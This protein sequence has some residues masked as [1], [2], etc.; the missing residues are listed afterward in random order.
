MYQ[1]SKHWLQRNALLLFNESQSD[2]FA[3]NNETT[4]AAGGKR[5][6]IA[7]KPASKADL[8]VDKRCGQNQY[9]N[10]CKR[11]EAERKNCEEKRRGEGTENEETKGNNKA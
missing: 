1:F 5:G 10:G 3:N 2:K 11:V 9:L 7:G 6:G 4:L 8:S